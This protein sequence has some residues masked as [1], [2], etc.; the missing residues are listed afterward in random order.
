MALK[1]PSKKHYD[2][3]I[4]K[5]QQ[6]CGD[7]ITHMEDKEDVKGVPSGH[8]DLDAVM[9]KGASGFYKGGILEI[10]GSEGSGK[11]SVAL[12]TV[13]TAQK[14]GM[15]CA[16]I[17]AEA[18]FDINLAKLN[19]VNP[20]DLLAPELADTSAFEKEESDEQS[21]SLFSAGKVLEIMYKIICSNVVDVIILDSV[22]G[23]MLRQ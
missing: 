1:I 12:R 9:T 17:D 22:A 6:D 5:L 21:L 23:L 8:E 16:W 14:L 13:G 3:I 7:G 2:A 19:G 4:K 20:S 15:R 18:G 11:T 10:F